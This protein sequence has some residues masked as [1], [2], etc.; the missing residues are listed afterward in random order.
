[1]STINPENKCAHLVEKYG[2]LPKPTIQ[3]MFAMQL[4]LQEF[5]ASRGKA[6]SPSLATPQERVSDITRQW[7][8]F[9]LEFAELLER[10]PFKEWKNYTTDDWENALSG[11][12]LLETKFEYIDMWHFFMNVG[13]LLGIDG[14]EFSQLYAIKNKENYDRQAQG[15]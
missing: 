5:Y 9:N 7:R 11:D 14:D 8:N 1:M 3:Q 10:L 6:T 13:L 4:Q 15:Y 12:M 2:E